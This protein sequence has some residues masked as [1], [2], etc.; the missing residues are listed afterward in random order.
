[1]VA[2][3]ITSITGAKGAAE[4]KKYWAYGDGRQ[5]W[6]N[7]PHPYTRLVELLRKYVS[8]RV[9]KGEAANIFKLA[10]GHYPGQRKDGQRL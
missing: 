1:M 7:D 5:K 9:A 3:S 8:G 2:T 10:T 4:L 6:I